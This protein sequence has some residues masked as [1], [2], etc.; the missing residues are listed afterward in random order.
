MSTSV[1]NYLAAVIVHHVFDIYISYSANRYKRGVQ[2]EVS[3]FILMISE[4]IWMDSYVA[5]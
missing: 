5:V 4:M 3:Y 1:H 2:G